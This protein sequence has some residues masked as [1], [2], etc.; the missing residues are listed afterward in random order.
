MKLL[1]A[2]DIFPPDAG[3]P[4]TYMVALAND[5]VKQGDEVTVVTL[6]PHP[7]TQAVSCPLF[8]APSKNRC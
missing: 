5:L 2:S 6:N 1:L 4:A 8:F 7:D 3:G